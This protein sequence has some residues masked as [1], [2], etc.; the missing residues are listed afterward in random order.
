MNDQQYVQ[1]CRALALLVA[2]GNPVARRWYATLKRSVDL[3]ES[4]EVF[5]EH[6]RH[7]R[8]ELKPEILTSLSNTDA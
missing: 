5:T 1:F 7:A 2:Q 8:E 3:G 6:Y 4:W